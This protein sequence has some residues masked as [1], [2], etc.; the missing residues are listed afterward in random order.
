MDPCKE[1]VSSI[2]GSEMA[3]FR[4]RV[5][6]GTGASTGADCSVGTEGSGPESPV[7]VYDGACPICRRYA[8][9]IRAG[10]AGE[11]M[12]ADAREGGPVVEE[13][14]SLPWDL[15]RGMALKVGDSYRLG[16]DAL[17]ELAMRTARGGK[18]GAVIRLLVGSRSGSRIAYPLLKLGRLVSLRLNGAG[19]L[20]RDSTGDRRRDC[21]SAAGRSSRD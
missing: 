19:P 20:E 11:V 17:R 13:A 3:R 6:R 7:L 2:T 9:F 10:S 12:L 21:D 18:A 1:R 16:P 5:E 8:Q 4:E 14:R 15:N